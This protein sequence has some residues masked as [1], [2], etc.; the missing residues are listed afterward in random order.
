MRVWEI[1]APYENLGKLLENTF[2]SYTRVELE[3]WIGFNILPRCI[4]REKVHKENVSRVGKSRK[5]FG[6]LTVGKIIFFPDIH[7]KLSI[8]IRKTF[9]Q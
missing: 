8:E 4:Y 2:R 9:S 3:L 6:K 7:E 1:D 5:I